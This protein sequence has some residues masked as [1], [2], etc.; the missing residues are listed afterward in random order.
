[1]YVI[2]IKVLGPVQVMDFQRRSLLVTE[3]AMFVVP[4]LSKLS[5]LRVC[6]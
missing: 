1:M 5:A 3:A 4:L 2:V 6:I